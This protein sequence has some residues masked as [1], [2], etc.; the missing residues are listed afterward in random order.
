MKRVAS[1]LVLVLAWLGSVDAAWLLVLDASSAKVLCTGAGCEAVLGSPWAHVAGVPLALLGVVHY[2]LVALAGAARLAWPDARSP[3][4]GL[5]VLGALGALVS[6]FLTGVQAFSLHA[7][8]PYCLGSAAISLLIAGALVL[9]RGGAARAPRAFLAAFVAFELATIAVG[10]RERLAVPAPSQPARVVAVDATRALIVGDRDA[11]LRVTAFLDY[12]CPRCRE[13]WTRLSELSRTS[14]GQVAIACY[15]YELP[16]HPNSTLAARAAEFA[17]EWARFPIYHDRVLTG[18]REL[19][20][21][22]LVSLGKELGL[23]ET[24]LHDRLTKPGH[25]SR[26]LE[27]SAEEAKRLGVEGVPATFVGGRRLDWPYSLDRLREEVALVSS[28]T[29]R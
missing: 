24:R 1:I 19:D 20:L 12:E 18:R 7:F 16:G 25:K 14:S 2:G 13:A 9:G 6:L 8:C 27:A 10:A 3:G 17:N 11:P 26:W 29:S 23:N 5:G 28:G 22:Y 4:R 21:K 15:H